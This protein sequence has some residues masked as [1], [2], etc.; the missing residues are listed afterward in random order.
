M[1]QIV[2]GARTGMGRESGTLHLTYIDHGAAPNVRALKFKVLLQ[3]ALVCTHRVESRV[4]LE[5][6]KVL[7]RHVYVERDARIA[8]LLEGLLGGGAVFIVEYTSLPGGEEASPD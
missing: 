2:F 5:D 1:F 7:E 3:Q 6:V 4:H 8:I